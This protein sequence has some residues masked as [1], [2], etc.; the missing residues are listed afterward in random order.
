MPP[1]RSARSTRPAPS[2]EGLGHVH[3]HRRQRAAPDLR[4]RGRRRPRFHGAVP[5]G[6]GD[7]PGRHRDPRRALPRCATPSRATR[8]PSGSRP[9]PHSRTSWRTC[10]I[11]CAA[12]T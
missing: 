8:P 10:S 11:A 6:A 9:S 1:W 12:R 2:G 4:Q 3:G 7:A 5:G